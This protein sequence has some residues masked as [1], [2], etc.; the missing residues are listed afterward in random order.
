MNGKALALRPN[1]MQRYRQHGIA[2]VD[3]KKL[4]LLSRHASDGIVLDIEPLF[5]IK[6]PKCAWV[7]EHSKVLVISSGKQKSMGHKV[8]PLIKKV[9]KPCLNI[10]CRLD[11]R[12]PQ[13]ELAYRS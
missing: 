4:P 8:I 11:G 1:D 13:I 12:K 6:Q 9:C 3:L 10:R 5:R 7:N 2:R